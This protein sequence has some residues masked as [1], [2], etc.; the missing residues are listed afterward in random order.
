M[1][2]GQAQV[3]V[4]IPN[5]TIAQL[6]QVLSNAVNSSIAFGSGQKFDKYKGEI[7]Y[8]CIEWID[9]FV[10]FTNFKG[11]GD[12][13]RFTNFNQ[14]LDGP[15]KSWYKLKVKKAA[16][17][18]TDWAGLRTAF[19]DYF[20]PD[21][22]AQALRERMMNRK[23]GNEPVQV[24]LTDK[25]L[26]CLDMN[27]AMQFDEQRRYLIDGLHNDIK[28]TL[29]P[30]NNPDMNTLVRNAKNIEKGLKMANK[31][32]YDTETINESKI[33]QSIAQKLEEIHLE[34]IENKSKIADI[35]R[36]SRSRDR[37]ET[38]RT[39]RYGRR[40]E[41]RNDRHTRERYVNLSRDSSPGFNKEKQI[42]EITSEN[43]PNT[44]STNYYQPRNQTYQGR[45]NWSPRPNQRSY[46]KPEFNNAR[47]VAFS[48]DIDGVIR[49]FNCGKPGHYA[50]DCRFRERHFFENR[51]QRSNAIQ[52]QT[53]SSESDQNDELIYQT[54]KINNQTIESLLD[55]GSE[56]SLINASLV[57]KLNLPIKP[58]N[59]KYIRAVNG[60][61]VD[62]IGQ[63]K[64]LVELE[65]EDFV[66]ITTIHAII[67]E[68][69][70]FQLLLGNDFNRKAGVFIDCKEKRLLC[71]DNTGGLVAPIELNKNNLE[72]NTIHLYRDTLFHPHTI[73]YIN[74]VPT[75][76]SKN[77]SIIC[78]VKTN[79]D[80]FKK[81]RLYLS[82][83]PITFKKGKACITALN[84]NKEPIL[85][86]SGTVIGIFNPNPDKITTDLEYFA[87]DSTSEEEENTKPLKGQRIERQI[88]FLRGFKEN[89]YIFDE[90]IYQKNSFNW[91]KFKNEK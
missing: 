37:D 90:K 42:G 79:Q 3:G 77:K 91:E 19:L 9:N 64:I 60:N 24:Y 86:K 69:F 83:A 45:N 17:P 59:G 50:R 52:K 82:D 63:V 84:C 74:V 12:T 22:Q 41:F 11:W 7:S 33:L 38:E 62:V 47:R 44:G 14:F 43:K 75:Y 30:A 76:K 8:D 56:I 1:A 32:S 72:G 40:V 81:Y 29:I 25:Q 71:S 16:N 67:V 70:D 23:Q 51:T 54:V 39:D 80:L 88:N 34:N 55:T 65:F 68:K 89:K 66:K 10:E 31:L 57:R 85:L 49:C 48:R 73:H 26:L 28:A 35:E 58:Y 21:D 78:K 5:M 2:Q 13:E 27:S 4:N 6:R 36:K 20:T 15:A 53:H 61:N 18:P 46:S 87:D